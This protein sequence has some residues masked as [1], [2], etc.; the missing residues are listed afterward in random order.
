MHP[1]AHA[2]ASTCTRITSTTRHHFLNP[3]LTSGWL[4]LSASALIPIQTKLTSSLPSQ[5]EVDSVP[6]CGEGLPDDLGVQIA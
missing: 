2:H 4:E 5:N 3:K 1:Q 6:V